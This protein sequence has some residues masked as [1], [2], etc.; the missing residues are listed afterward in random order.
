[1]K[2]MNGVAGEF[3][4]NKNKQGKDQYFPVFFPFCIFQFPEKIGKKNKIFPIK[5]PGKQKKYT[6]YIIV[7]KSTHTTVVYV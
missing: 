4:F 6:A 7:V 3:F 1:M 2:N 5:S